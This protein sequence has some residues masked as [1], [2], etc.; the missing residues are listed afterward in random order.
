MKGWKP[1]KRETENKNVLDKVDLDKPGNE[2]TTSLHFNPSDLSKRSVESKNHI[3][4][5]MKKDFYD[6]FKNPIVILVLL[7]IIVL[8]SLYALVNIVACW[9]PYGNTVNV[10]FAIANEDA[11]ATYQNY[12]INAG[13][14][15]VD[16]LK[17]NDD[18]KWKFVTSEELRRGVHNGTYYAGMIIPSNFSESIVS[19]T[20]DNPHSADL[21][22]IV[23][24]KTSPV[25]CKL[26]DAAAR[27]V[28][29]KLNAEIVSFINV[30]AYGKLSELEEGLASG[31]DKMHDGAD[32]LSAGADKVAA[33]AD[34]LTAGAG[35]V[36]NGADRLSGGANQL[37]GGSLAVSTGARSVSNGAYQLADGSDKVAS[38]ASR[39]A[40]GTHEISTK[41]N[42]LYNKT[43]KIEQDLIKRINSS[44]IKN[45]AGEIESES[46]SIS[47]D[48]NKLANES[49]IVSDGATNVSIEVGNLSND[50]EIVA[51]RSRQVSNRTRDIASEFSNVSRDIAE[52]AE[53]IKSGKEQDKIIELLERI[54][55]KLSETNQKFNQLD[56]GAHQVANGSESV[57]VGANTLADGSSQ[58]ADGASR[59]YY[60]ANQLSA[61]ADQ[62][63]SG[64]HV[65][66]N[67]TI[68]LATG[69]ELLGNSAANALNTAAGSLD[70]ATGQL[71]DVTGLSD[72]QVEDYFLSPVKLQRQ[73]E[74]PTNSYGSQVSPF[75][76]VL[77]MWVGALITCVMLRT[78][79]VNE[80]RYKPQEVYLGKLVIFNIVAVLQTTV[81]IIGAF[82]LGIGIRDP[83]MFI[84][85]CYFISVV[86]MAIVYSLISVFGDV[87]KGIAILLLVFQI[88]GTGGVYPIE[89]ISELFGGLYPIMPMTH[90]INILREA[91][92]GLI[93]YNYLPS[94]AYLLIL[95]VVL[96]I[97]SLLLK[98]RWDKRTQY[99]EDNLNESDLF[100]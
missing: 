59:L 21:E 28:Y 81:T 17:E 78:G 14:D 67:G 80:E 92:L 31:A 87:G 51:Q 76:L 61:G 9:D 11:G 57:S 60:G 32:Q 47:E 53:L 45:R 46:R 63:A 26:T 30:V 22:Y 4:E 49:E 88:S 15:L 62:L 24:M 56:T 20:T 35:K 25:A 77:S 3:S 38:G 43:H 99:F 2:G 84:F 94:F 8:P 42:E 64:V 55:L 83:L 72:D 91:Q 41:S 74:F 39:V 54:D 70:D 16:S 89:I 12:T 6:A 18:F 13:N 7:A 37:A 1:K 40:D 44:D 65:L 5:I 97:L 58:L 50:A 27:N 98:Q 33:G 93:W 19:I 86:F 34:E 52:V 90:G 73:E 100:N 79:V 82:L 23:N 68:K 95:V 75:Y 48:L 85:T 96:L 69:A 29:N 71:S 10:E 36:S 66:S